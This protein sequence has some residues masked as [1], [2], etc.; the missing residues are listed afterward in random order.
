MNSKT[1]KMMY[2]RQRDEMV[3][4]NMNVNEWI[5]CTEKLPEVGDTYLVTVTYKGEVL[6]VDAACFD[7]DCHY[8]DDMWATYNDWIE[9]DPELYHV[10]AWMP[11]PDAYEG[12][13]NNG[14]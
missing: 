3:F 4:M 2:D 5:P 8:I 13:E 1:G 9:G 12:G 14:K 7:P 6:A 11:L 10:T